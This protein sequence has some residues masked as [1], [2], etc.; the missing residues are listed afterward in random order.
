MFFNCCFFLIIYKCTMKMN[1]LNIEINLGLI[2]PKMSHRLN[3]Q[4]KDAE[5]F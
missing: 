2:L 3:V 4:T 5:I 1:M